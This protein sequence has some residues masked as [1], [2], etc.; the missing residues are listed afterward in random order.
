MVKTIL[1]FRLLIM[2]PA[3]RLTPV[4][5]VLPPRLGEGLVTRRK[6]LDNWIVDVNAEFF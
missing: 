2:K 1:T 4:L 5:I 6:T 3:E